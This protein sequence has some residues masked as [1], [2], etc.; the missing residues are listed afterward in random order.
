MRELERVCVA[1]VEVSD[2]G[3]KCR[4]IFVV[5]IVMGIIFVSVLM[6]FESRLCYGYESVSFFEAAIH[7]F[8][9]VAVVYDFMEG[10]TFKDAF[11]VEHGIFRRNNLTEVTSAGQL[12]SVVGTYT[13]F[14]AV[15]ES[16]FCFSIK[17]ATCEVVGILDECFDHFEEVGT[18]IGFFD[19]VL[20]LV[21]GD[22]E[23]DNVYG[24]TGT[25]FKLAVG[26]VA[27][28]NGRLHVDTKGLVHPFG[29]FSQAHEERV[30]VGVLGFSLLGEGDKAR[31]EWIQYFVIYFDM[32]DFSLG[33]TFF[34]G[35]VAYLVE[36][37]TKFVLGGVACGGF[38]WQVGGGGSGDL[39]FVGGPSHGGFPL[40]IH[41][42]V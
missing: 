26:C 38:G 19:V 7:T 10:H 3:N 23:S 29:I 22:D 15:V 8:H 4:E 30:D 41:E 14:I 11:H 35:L 13:E 1:P 34:E 12:A 2:L 5:A 6:R 21:E 27:A 18:Y 40:L 32:G 36:G 9:D 17:R 33:G 24:G 31:S 25:F 28:E 42:R 39:I 16:F 37:F 20:L